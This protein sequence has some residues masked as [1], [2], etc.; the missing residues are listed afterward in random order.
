[1]LQISF[2]RRCNLIRLLKTSLTS[3]EV[4]PNSGLSVSLRP[5]LLIEHFSA[6]VGVV[7]CC[8]Q[9]LCALNVDQGYK[10]NSSLKIDNA[11]VEMK[12]N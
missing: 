4:F 1:M 3:A 10:I 7:T 2:Q 8:Y 11:V 6:K 9:P 5:F 12:E